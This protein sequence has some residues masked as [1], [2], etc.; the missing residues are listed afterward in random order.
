MSRSL[1]CNIF[2]IVCLIIG[3]SLFFGIY[4]GLYRKNVEYNAQYTQDTCLVTAN[5]ITNQSC[6]VISQ[7]TC[8]TRSC[9]GTSCYD[10][11]RQHTSG[12]C[13]GNACCALKNNNG[14]CL[15]S[16]I[17]TQVMVWGICDSVYATFHAVGLNYTFTEDVN[18]CPMDDTYCPQ[19]TMLNYHIGS[20]HPCWISFHPDGSLQATAADPDKPTQGPLAGAIIGLVCM[21]L[22]TFILLFQL[23]EF[24]RRKHQNRYQAF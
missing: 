3:I 21:G 17:Q 24:C 18:D 14:Q 5:W 23:G 1:A 12:Q 19:T 4:F 7:P 20:S 9:S 15:V 6:Y 22:G 11:I 16:S 2:A 13:C 8:P 10:R